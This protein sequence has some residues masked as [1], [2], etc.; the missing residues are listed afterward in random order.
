MLYTLSFSG[1]GHLLPY[2]LGV[3]V[4]LLPQR[5]RL[6]AVAGSS[7]GA[8]AATVLSLLSHRL[9]E[10]LERFINARG[11]AYR[12]LQQML[13]E[14]QL[15]QQRSQLN[16]FHLQLSICTTKCSDGKMHLH[17]F[18]AET[19]LS[20][21][22][23]TNEVLKAVQASCAIPRSFHPFDMFSKQPLSFPDEEGVEIDGA[24]YV[25]GGIAAPVPP[26]SL[27]G[28]PKCLGRIE[29]SPISGPKVQSLVPTLSI[30]PCDNSLPLL[31]FSLTTTRCQPF[32]IR[33]S[34]QNVRALV[35]S[36]GLANPQVLQDWY[37]RGIDDA[38]KFVEEHLEKK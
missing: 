34:L 17:S 14:E 35:V 15:E 37:Q 28:D 36:A 16:D 29:V 4:T 32:S 12:N 20:D 3:A 21:P 5:H 13:M 33:P 22:S 10:Y 19:V 30:R 9:E 27:D 1:A 2:H 25:D 7:S 38:S 31:P 6:L 26:T 11:H 24:Y 23:Q 18:D 8:I